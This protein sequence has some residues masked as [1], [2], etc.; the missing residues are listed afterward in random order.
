M[1][2][3]GRKTNVYLND[4]QLSEKNGLNIGSL[5]TTISDFSF[6]SADQKTTTSKEGSLKVQLNDIKL[7][8]GNKLIWS[9]SAKEIIARNF[10][11]DSIGTNPTNRN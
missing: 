8:P 5:N 2:W 10:S 3:D 6:T 4:L 11:A 7:K 9:A 1:D